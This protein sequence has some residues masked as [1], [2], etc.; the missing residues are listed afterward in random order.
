M[1]SRSWQR[2]SQVL[3]LLLV[4]LVGAA[5]IVAFLRPGTP[6][7]TP[8]PSNTAIVSPTPTGQATEPP[9]ATPSA[10][11]GPSRTPKPPKSPKPTATTTPTPRPTATARSSETSAPSTPR[12][13]EPTAI[14]ARKI[15]FVG[16]GFDSTAAATPKAR[17]IDFDT[18]G[19]GTVTAKLTK[20]SSGD[21]HFCLQR[22]GAS[23]TCV[24]DDHA[25]LSGT[26]SASGKTSWVVTGIG[27]G[28]QSPIADVIIGFA[29]LH[30]NVSVSDFRFQG[31]E[32]QG[33]NGVEADLN[34]GAGTIKVRGTITSAHPW[35]VRLIDGD[36]NQVANQTGSGTQIAYQTDTSTNNLHL[37]IAGTELLTEEEVFLDAT[38]RWQ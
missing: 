18:D 1:S 35:R 19:P 21:V 7:T 9:G 6:A 2:L 10:T 36:F 5:A 20:T 3:A 12:P 14:P 23:Q 32:N 31:T 33:F 4:V 27:T 26:T 24:D 28:A 8:S 38:I 34:N 29:A 16:L 37:T 30:P 11:P 17:T 25:N 13:S 22:V 15:Q